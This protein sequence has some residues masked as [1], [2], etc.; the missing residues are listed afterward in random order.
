MEGQPAEVPLKVCP[1]C[2][3]A[4]RTDAGSTREF[5]VH[6]YCL[7]TASPGYH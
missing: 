2:S 1:H 7:T 4:S 3:V 6:A 5:R